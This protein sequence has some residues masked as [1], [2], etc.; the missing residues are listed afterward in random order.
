MDVVLYVFEIPAETRQS[1]A[2]CCSA[3][4]KALL[5]LIYN[6]KF[7]YHRCIGR[8][9]NGKTTESFLGITV[10]SFRKGLGSKYSLLM[11]TV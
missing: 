5:L 4:Q 8:G 1:N 6:I 2:R 9:A 11:I 3:V 10:F 7:I